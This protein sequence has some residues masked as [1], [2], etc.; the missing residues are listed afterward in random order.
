[1]E[2]TQRS[3]QVLAL[4]SSV[5][6]KQED[7]ATRG[8]RQPRRRCS[9]IS[10]RLTPEARSSAVGPPTGAGERLR[11]GREQ[12]PTLPWVALRPAA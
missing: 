5:L 10:P 12:A 1:M 4:L 6:T 7:D 11:L 3:L 8:T 9:R 2:R